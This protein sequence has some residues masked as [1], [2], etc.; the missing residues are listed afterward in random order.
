M[1]C[2]KTITS[3]SGQTYARPIFLLVFFITFVFNVKSLLFSYNQS[4]KLS[5]NRLLIPKLSYLLTPFRVDPHHNKKIP[6]GLYRVQNNTK[7]HK[8]TN[9]VINIFPATFLTKQ[10]SIKIKL[11]YQTQLKYYLS[12]ISL[13]LIQPSFKREDK[14]NSSN[15][16]SFLLCI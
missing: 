15:I 1:H 13:F 10:L 5:K 8:K 7:L 4:Q 6:T 9:T 3:S 12:N 16:F 14:T 2:K 11:A